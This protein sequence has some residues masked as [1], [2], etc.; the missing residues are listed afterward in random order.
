MGTISKVLSAFLDVWFSILGSESSWNC[1]LRGG[2]PT[3]QE[4]PGPAPGTQVA[5]VE[6]L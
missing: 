5:I 2:S 6:S 1:E 4:R 3:D